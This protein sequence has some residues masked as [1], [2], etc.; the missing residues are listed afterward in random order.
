MKSKLFSMLQ[1]NILLAGIVIV[2]TLITS[3][4]SVDL[5]RPEEQV[6]K[7]FQRL[8]KLQ[9]RDLVSATIDKITGVFKVHGS[10]RTHLGLIMEA[11]QG[12]AQNQIGHE[13]LALLQS[14]RE[15]NAVQPIFFKKAGT[16]SAYVSPTFMGVWDHVGASTGS[17][18]FSFY[19]FL[20]E[21][22]MFDLGEP[23]ARLLRSPD[24]RVLVS[25]GHR[26]NDR[27]L[28]HEVL[29]VLRK[30]KGNPLRSNSCERTRK[31]YAKELLLQPISLALRSEVL[32]EVKNLWFEDEEVEVIT[33][34]KLD[35]QCTEFFHL[36]EAAFA[37]SNVRLFHSSFG[38]KSG[39]HDGLDL[40]KLCS[41]MPQNPFVILMNSQ[42]TLDLY[43][44]YSPSPSQHD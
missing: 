37:P 34:R 44:P 5:P 28:V 18:L 9:P 41:K 4:K 20:D 15:S 42:C 36:S 3:S 39:F 31:L 33:G 32:D 19:C 29:H 26:D 2:A 21:K 23:H 30:F 10:L 35:S 8:N 38:P 13:A 17:K 12:A 6:F 11:L 22:F 43:Q 1:S 40:K 14:Y 7:S 16:D 24:V 25:I 27:F